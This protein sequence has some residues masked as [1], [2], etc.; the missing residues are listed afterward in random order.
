MSQALLND[1]YRL[2]DELGQGG[3]GTVHRAFDTTLEREVAVKLVTGYEMETEGRARLL[4]EAKSIAQLNHPNIVTVHDAGEM[5]QTPYIVMELIEGTS[6]HETPPA[7]L[8]RLV[9]IAAQICAALEHAHERDIVHRDLKPENVLIDPE[10]NA[11]L[12]DFGIA[13]SMASRMT[14]EGRIEGTVFY[15]APELAL[16]KEYDGRA[17]LYALGVMLYEL[18]TGELPFQQGDPV[19]IISQHVNAPVVRPRAKDPEIP[20]GLDKLI[21][22][23]M[24]KDPEDRP[25]TAAQ[26]LNVLQRPGLLDTSGAEDE[27]LSTLD[28]IVRGRMI[29][30]EAEFDKA[31][32]LWYEATEGK[33]QILL[34]SGEPGVGKTRLL[35]EIITQSEVMGAQV[36]G[37]ASYAEGG[38]PY[39]PFK[40]IL[41]EV[42]PK[43]SQNGFNLPNDVVADL[44]SLAPEFRTQYPDIPPNPAEDPQSDQH[45]LFE[46]FFVFM[47]AL[48]Q[49]TPLLVYL[50]DAHWADSG[51]LGLFRHLARQLGSQPIMLLAT[52]REIELDEAR[53]LN[54]VLLDISREPQTT[55]LKLNRL[56]MEQTE[57]L[58]ASFFQ[59]EIT[60]EFLEGIYRET[61]GNPFFIEEVCKALVESGK[62]L[63]EDGSWDRPDM[64]ELG[65]PQSVRVA[66][67]SR[68]SKLTPE[69]QKILSQAAVLGRELDFETLSLA[70]ET[71][72]DSLIDGLE[73]A[74]RAQLIE[75]HSE[76]GQ[77]VFSFS[78]ALIPST[79]VEGLRVLQRRRLHRHAAEALEK[80]DPENYNAIGQHLL[81]AGKSKRGVDYLLKAGDQARSLHAHEEAI[82]AY[83]QA[84]DY[85]RETEDYGRAARTLM[86]LGLTYHNALQFS[87]SRQAYDEGFIYWQRSAEVKAPASEAIAPHPLRLAADPPT[88]LDPVIAHDFQSSMY[89]EQLFSG[90]LQLTPDTSIEPDVARSWDVL[91]N[92]KKYRFHLR[93]DVRWSDGRP[94]T[95]IDFEFAWKRTLDPATGSQ[96]NDLLSDIRGAVDFSRGEGSEEDVGLHAEDDY[97]LFIELERPT[98]YFLQFLANPASFPIPKH[99]VKADEKGWADPESIVTNGPF[100]IA[101]LDSENSISLE[102]NP[103]YHGD[104]G[105]NVEQVQV[106]FLNRGTDE[107]SRRYEDDEIDVQLMYMLDP[108]TRD[109]SRHSHP[110]EYLTAPV[111]SILYM[112]FN[113]SRPPFDDIRVRRAFCKAIDLETLAEIAYRG[114]YAPATGGIVPPGLPS[115]LPDLGFRYDPKSAANLLEEAGYPAGEG[116]PEI[117]WLGSISGLGDPIRDHLKSQWGQHL[118]IKFEWQLMD[119]ADY[120]ERLNNDPPSVYTTGWL[121]DYP[122]PDNFLRLALRRTLKTWDSE[123]FDELVE[124]AR[125]T[126][127]LSERVDLYEQAQRLLVEELPVFPLV[128]LRGHY[129][130]KP[131]V[132]KFPVSTMRVNYW[133]DTVIEPHD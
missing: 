27:Q 18:T 131:W 12:M 22:Q 54:E 7:D 42:L 71:D 107:L 5:D 82:S 19:A 120:D 108:E 81:E 80:R 86:K 103:E 49:H 24:A 26:T 117:E 124:T 8:D 15:M 51:S 40:Q 127:N 121:A 53:P 64:S 133:N 74:D 118:G 84:L 13:R 66:I 130:L 29:G 72:E 31:R 126:L 58:L 68:I 59:D 61:D 11:K 43:A 110:D 47:A 3:M 125:R 109:R 67:Q 76:N 30:R 92:G 63:F 112:G 56:T 85:A 37:S 34:V 105:G 2:E 32:E 50:D 96:N 21:V 87:E 79:L 25:A 62:L 129:L 33:S 106:S 44:L 123:T 17:D 78:H 65:I 128:Y 39:S 77:L 113:L 116:F 10:G 114:S 70:A 89:T 119:W 38:P 102:R 100:R 41:R 111:L 98:G 97:T 75:E 35:R 55:R 91:D 14:Q 48:S 28:R 88:T 104:F 57:Q 132:T 4:Q 46:S 90:L 20:T 69:T 60:P 94:V 1:R 73:E 99:A 93:D 45:R 9:H 23:L 101:S 115:H 95:S 36:L 52:Y 83:L 122:D 6:L 16:G